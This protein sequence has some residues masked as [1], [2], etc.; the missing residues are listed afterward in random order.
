VA[1]PDLNL[2][3]VFRVIGPISAALA[4]AAL[5]LA[6]PSPAEGIV[7]VAAFIAVALFVVR[8]SFL[9]HERT[10]TLAEV[11]SIYEEHDRLVAELREELLERGRVEVQLISDTRFAAVGEL[12]AGVAHEVNNPLTSVLGFAEILLEDLD[13]EDPRRQDVQ[14]IRDSALQARAVVRALRD[15]ARP[16][17]PVLEPTDLPDLVTRMIDLV[18][19]PL[20][21]AGVMIVESHAELPLITLD[22]QAIQEVILNVLTNAMQ[23]MPD[24]GTLRIDSSIRGSKAVVTITDD[25]VGM[26]EIVAAQAFV[27]FFSGRPAAESTGLGLSAS[28]GLVESHRGTIHLSSKEGVGTTVV[29]SLP[30]VADRTGRDDPYRLVPA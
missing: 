4:C 17:K 14:T 11:Q 28:L 7:A 23:A 22:P 19:Y 1:Q 2:R 29:I 9:L 16:G 13:H 30:I 18:R 10:T 15:F 5:L 3:S 27:P 24:G 21:R 25:G 20:T 26:D 6:L 8:L 12:A